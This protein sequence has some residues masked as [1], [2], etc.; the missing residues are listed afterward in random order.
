MSLRDAML[1][2]GVVD[3]KKVRDT[4]RALKE[5]RRQEQG[6]RE[7]RALVE[8]REAAL[9]AAEREED[10]RR[11]R[12]E[13]ARRESEQAAAEGALR[14]RHLLRHHRLRV[15][16]GMV[17]FHHRA[18]D[19]PTLVAWDLPRFVAEGLRDGRLAVAA[20]REPGG[21]AYALIVAEVALKVQAIRPEDL[22]FFNVT[23]P[24]SDPAE[25][26][27]PPRTTPDPEATV[28]ELRRRLGRP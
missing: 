18:A 10:Q 26:L 19:G 2:A 16:S 14:V 6:H 11:Q 21:V 25:A 9:L 13:R 15:G 22:V 8:A 17:R 1:K 23:P 5:S 12:E 7:A 27:L 24:G 3:K 4:E 28:A 20:L